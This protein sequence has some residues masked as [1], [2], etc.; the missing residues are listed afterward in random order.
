MTVL[1]PLPTSTQLARNWQK[2]IVVACV[3]TAAGFLLLSAKHHQAQNLARKVLSDI[4]R[5]GVD[6]DFSQ[7]Q[8]ESE[9]RCPQIPGAEDVLVVIKTG[10]TEA[11]TKLPRHFSTT[12]RC[13]PHHAIFS[14]LSEVIAGHKVHDVLDVVPR[15]VIEDNQHEFR[16]Y[17]EM[18]TAKATGVDVATL[19]KPGE[20][21]LGRNLDKW[22]FLPM[23]KKAY[24]TKPDAK[25]FV[26]L[27]AD[28]SLMWSNLLQYLSFLDPDIPEYSGS[29]AGSLTGPE[30]SFAHGGSGIIMSSA[31][32]KIAVDALARDQSYYSWPADEC[33]G[34]LVLS[35]FLAANGVNF[36]SAYPFIQGE[37]PSTFAYTKV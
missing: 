35:K 24:E 15:E 13:I 18:Q 10:A 11:H 20:R 23:L 37:T 30:N 9:I 33:C 29:P 28:T 6:N 31:A 14:D 4:Y 7:W 22:K 19:V 1:W 25:W 3:L 36:T 21:N 34:D 8:A 2:N 16:I 32:V 5:S 27:E 12:L 17:S 26:F